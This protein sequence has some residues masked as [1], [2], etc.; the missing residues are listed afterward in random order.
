MALLCG[1][2]VFLQLIKRWV[3]QHGHQ[4]YNDIANFNTNLP[5]A[6]SKPFHITVTTDL[7]AMLRLRHMSYNE[8]KQVTVLFADG[9]WIPMLNNLL[10]SLERA[11]VHNYFV[12]SSDEQIVQVCKD[13]GLYCVDSRPLLGLDQNST[14]TRSSTNNSTNSTAAASEKIFG[15][16]SYNEMTFARYDLLLYV[17]EQGYD[18][19]HLDLDTVRPPCLQ[20][21]ALKM[22]KCNLLRRVHALGLLN[23][24]VV[25][26]HFAVVFF[27]C[28]YELD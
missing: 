3:A 11:T 22:R 7:A 18:V 19:L 4:K 26:V 6:S 9:P 17:L 5:L 24:T 12:I 15:T 13:Q 28:V 27:R 23:S 20:T 21:H 8:N 1:V 10:F 16:P 14:H 25:A 2:V